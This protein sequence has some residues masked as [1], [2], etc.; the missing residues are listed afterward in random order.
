MIRNIFPKRVLCLRLEYWGFANIEISCEIV[1]QNKVKN[2]G[3]IKWVLPR[4]ITMLRING[5]MIA[6]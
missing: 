1:I 5:V 4:F 2:L 6:I 3:N